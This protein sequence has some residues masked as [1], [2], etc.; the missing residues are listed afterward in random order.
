VAHRQHGAI[1]SLY[2]LAPGLMVFLARDNGDKEVTCSQAAGHAMRRRCAIA[3]TPPTPATTT[4]ATRSLVV[5]MRSMRARLRNT[6][7]DEDEIR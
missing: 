5:I 7:D 2:P 4:A 6:G 1:S 3:A